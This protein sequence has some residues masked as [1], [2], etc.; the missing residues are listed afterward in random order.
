[1]IID[2]TLGFAMSSFTESSSEGRICCHFC[3]VGQDIIKGKYKVKTA[4][5]LSEISDAETV[6]IRYSDPEGDEEETNPITRR[7]QESRHPRRKPATR[8]E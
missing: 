8:D 4:E 1:M 6:E 5:E 2:W 3:P 7:E